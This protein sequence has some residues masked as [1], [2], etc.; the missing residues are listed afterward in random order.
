MPN[1]NER[2]V[3]PELSSKSSVPMILIV[4][5]ESD[6]LELLELTLA[7]MGM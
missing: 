3:N 6:I 7:R 5:D 4:D 2:I 1:Q